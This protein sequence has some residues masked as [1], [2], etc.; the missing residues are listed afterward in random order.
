MRYCS[1]GRDGRSIRPARVLLVA[2]HADCVLLG[3]E[4]PDVTA[5]VLLESVRHK[6]HLSL[7]LHSRAFAVNALEAMS[8]EMKNLRGVVAELKSNICQV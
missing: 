8:P 6:F 7:D 5:T 2:T 1:P 4:S 3:D